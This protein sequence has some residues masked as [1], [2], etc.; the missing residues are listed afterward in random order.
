M[1]LPEFQKALNFINFNLK[2]PEFE[3]LSHDLMNKNQEI[4]IQEVCKKVDAWKHN[5]S[6]SF[7][8]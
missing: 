6:I 4:T 1:T 5:E 3:E 2:E 7:K 8:K